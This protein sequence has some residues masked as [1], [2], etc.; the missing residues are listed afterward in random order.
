MTWLKD[1]LLQFAIDRVNEIAK[2]LVVLAI[3]A[4]ND[5]RVD[6]LLNQI[7]SPVH[8]QIAV[9][10]IDL[11]EQVLTTVKDENVINQSLETVRSA[12]PAGVDKVVLSSGTEIK[13]N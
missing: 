8:R 4:I 13:L 2:G 5:G 1:L 11:V 7:K 3:G 9:L 10:V 12:L 6:E